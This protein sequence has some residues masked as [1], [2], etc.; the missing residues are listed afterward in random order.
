MTVGAPVT[1]GQFPI[2]EEVEVYETFA[3][4]GISGSIGQG[5]N[6]GWVA[7]SVTMPWAGCLSAKLT[8]NGWWNPNG[9]VALDTS[10]NASPWPSN[11]WGG[12]FQQHSRATSWEHATLLCYWQDLAKNTTVNIGMTATVPMASEAFQCSAIIG[13]MRAWRV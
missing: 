9:V 6:G 5:S 2:P 7:G 11:W 4:I 1:F 8:I 10:P 12:S 3:H 13:T